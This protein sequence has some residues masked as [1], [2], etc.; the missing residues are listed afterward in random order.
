MRS[1][2]GTLVAYR[3]DFYERSMCPFEQV[4]IASMRSY[5]SLHYNYSRKNHQGLVNYAGGKSDHATRDPHVATLG[6]TLRCLRATLRS[7]G[8]QRTPRA[9]R[10]QKQ[11]Q[12]RVPVPLSLRNTELFL[13]YISRANLKEVR[14]RAFRYVSRP[15]TLMTMNDLK[16]PV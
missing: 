14:R 15:L 7:R 4:F 6:T 5:E 10:R 2:F 13:T 3:V 8:Q 11:L 12:D 9:A 1:K 16:I